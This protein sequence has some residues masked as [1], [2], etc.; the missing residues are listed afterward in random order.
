MNKRG[1]L[2]SSDALLSIM[3]FLF[4]LTVISILTS[5]LEQQTVDQLQ[6]YYTTQRAERV[7]TSLFASPGEPAYWDTLSDRSTITKV[8]L[9]N[10][11]S[12]IDLQK[13]QALQDWNADDYAG[14]KTA[15]GIPDLNFYINIYDTNRTTLSQAG[16]APTDV[17]K[18][19]GVIIPTT[20]Q[21]TAALVAVQVYEE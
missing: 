12:G 14:L 10:G 11:H 9:T 1:Q 6:R 5:Q 19:N 8:G 20:Y 2:F 17:N 15:L 13:W 4:A 7:A 3:V 21:G 16:I 18:V